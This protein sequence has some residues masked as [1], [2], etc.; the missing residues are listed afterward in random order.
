MPD[1]VTRF[2]P[3]L[4][5]G[6]L[7]VG[8]LVNCFANLFFAR[9]NRGG[10]WCK[11]ELKVDPSHNP[12]V[13]V[14]D[15]YAYDDRS[16]HQFATN[17]VTLKWLLP[18]T[19]IITTVETQAIVERIL[20]IEIDEPLVFEVSL[21]V[22]M[23]TSVL[24]RGCEWHPELLERGPVELHDHECVTVGRNIDATFLRLTGRVPRVLYH[25]LLID[26]ASERKISKSE[27]EDPDYFNPLPGKPLPLRWSVQD[28]RV[29]DLREHYTR[30]TF[31]GF[32]AAVLGWDFA[33]DPLDGFLE[34][35]TIG[36]LREFTLP[37]R[38]DLLDEV[39]AVLATAW[40]TRLEAEE[41]YLSILEWD[42]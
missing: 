36:E 37:F 34:T 21:D 32:A 4:S 9:A 40:P 19:P 17:L 22:L 35:F 31:L 7:H 12:N 18:R 41:K 10:F 28:Y 30:L 26:P 38:R 5:T 15:D 24:I 25:P 11:C 42:A 6:P 33:A 27:L 1:V 29:R 3:T 14:L 8:H 23:D 20:G 13:G 2:C 39:A 16:W